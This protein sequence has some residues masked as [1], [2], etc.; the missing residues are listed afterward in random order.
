MK[1]KRNLIIIG[2]TNNAKLAHYYFSTDSDYIVKC[3]AVNKKFISEGFFCG[4]PVYPIEEIEKKFPIQN[5]DA[6]VAI[7]YSKMNSIREKIYIEIKTKGY[8]L[9]NYISS[10]CTYLTN[11]QIGDNNLIL[12]NNTIQPFVKI[13]NNNVIWSGNHIGHDVNI[14]NNC[15]ISSH[16]VISGFTTIENNCFLGV[17][18]TLRDNIIIR[19]FSLIGAGATIMKSTKPKSVMLDNRPSLSNKKS[20]EI[21]IS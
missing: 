3:F 12:E 4:L 2:T 6:F 7:G 9:P 20:T 11:E 1:E 21:T 5:Y 14:K 17:N 19:D 8:T 16:V 18:S 10:K 13:G 15:F